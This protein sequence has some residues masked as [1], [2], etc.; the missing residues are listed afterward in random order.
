MR[1]L[2]E[3]QA[4]LLPLRHLHARRSAMYERRSYACGSSTVGKA[5]TFCG[6]KVSA[7]KEFVPLSC[8]TSFVR[9]GIKPA[10]LAAAPARAPSSIELASRAAPLASL[11]C[12]A[13]VRR[14]GRRAAVAS[15]RCSLSIADALFRRRRPVPGLRSLPSLRVDCLL[16]SAAAASRLGCSQPPRGACLRRFLDGRRA[17]RPTKQSSAALQLRFC[18]CF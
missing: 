11:A 18:S 5:H 12:F 7:H 1:S 9:S 17:L 3:T 8:T 13:A 10:A 15:Y 2:V 14:R 6:T 16:H 4:F